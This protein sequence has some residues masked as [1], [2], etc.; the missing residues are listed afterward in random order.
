MI[1][2]F[3]N[4]HIDQIFKIEKINFDNPQDVKQFYIYLEVDST[5]IPTLKLYDN[6]DFGRVRKRKGYYN[7]N[8]DTI[9]MDLI[10]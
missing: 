8:K 6:L 7:N 2:T 3:S 4:K 5:N 10:L 9:L 1:K